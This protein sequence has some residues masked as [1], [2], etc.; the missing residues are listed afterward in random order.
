MC[1]NAE[2]VFYFQLPDFGNLKGEKGEAGVPGP[3]GPKGETGAPGKAVLV[4]PPPFTLPPPMP[5]P[6]GL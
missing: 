4:T 1:A 5:G 3:P 2:Y 6:K